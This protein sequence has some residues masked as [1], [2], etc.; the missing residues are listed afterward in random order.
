MISVD[1]YNELT[2]EIEELNVEIEGLRDELRGVRKTWAEE[3]KIRDEM[4]SEMTSG[5]T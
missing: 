4:I 2:T 3:I 1:R 5:M